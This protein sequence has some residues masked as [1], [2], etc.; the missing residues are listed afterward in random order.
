[1]V[2]SDPGGTIEQEPQGLTSPDGAIG[3]D[4]TRIELLDDKEGWVKDGA[5]I[6]VV[7][8]KAAPIGEHCGIRVELPEVD[9]DG[10]SY[11]I[12]SQ[13]EFAYSNLSDIHFL[14]VLERDGGDRRDVVLPA[15]EYTPPGASQP[16]PLVFRFSVQENDEAVGFLVH[17]RPN[18]RDSFTLRTAPPNATFDVT[19]Y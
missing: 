5:E 19:T 6:Y 11:P 12:S 16:E 2:T 1:V 14:F 9:Y 13:L 18:V 7:I 15:G 17:E 3:I 4:F 10:R 8:C